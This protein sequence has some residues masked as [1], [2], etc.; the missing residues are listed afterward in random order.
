M[1]N[2]EQINEVVT[3]MRR[4]QCIYEPM[5]IEMGRE[6]REDISERQRQMANA[7]TENLTDEHHI[8]LRKQIYNRR[9]QLEAMSQP[10]YI[11]A[12][13]TF[14]LLAR[15]IR[16]LPA[17]W[18]QRQPNEILNFRWMMDGKA[19]QGITPAEEW[20]DM[21]KGGFLQ[22]KLAKMPMI[23]IEGCDTTAFYK[24]FRMPMP[25]YLR[26]TLLPNIDEGFDLK[27]L[28]EEHFTFSAA[29]EYGLELVDIL[30]NATRRAL[31]GNLGKHG[32]QQ[33]PELM[34]SRRGGSLALTSLSK[35]ADVSNLPYS[36][37]IVKD[38]GRGGRHMIARGLP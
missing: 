9:A 22:S 6:S 32:W 2:E 15:V 3:W 18:M 25:E 30:T 8:N 35:A 1:L 37:I 26:G 20:W 19:V 16:D 11:Q 21:M 12:A 38:F 14:E 10:L 28:L 4:N 36:N 29:P 13:L 24:K 27:L 7:L 5:V 31:K 23:A 17:Y 33:I 34:I